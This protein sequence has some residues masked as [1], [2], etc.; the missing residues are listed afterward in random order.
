MNTTQTI[1]EGKVNQIATLVAVKTINGTSFVGVRNYVNSKGEMSNQT[2]LVGIDYGKLLEKDFK[3]L[4]AFDIKKFAKRYKENL[5][6]VETAYGELLLSLRKRTATE[7]EKA[8]LR[9]S[10]DKTIKMS[11]AQKDA[12]TQVAKGLKYKDGELYIYGLCVRKEVLIEGD[13]P[14]VNSSLKTIIKKDIKRACELKDLKYKQ[15]KLGEYETLNVQGFT[16]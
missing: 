14:Q 15:F 6:V 5:D 11:D 2:F 12:Y 13:Y 10:G 3:A 16:I 7:F 8:I 9:E 1:I 4:K